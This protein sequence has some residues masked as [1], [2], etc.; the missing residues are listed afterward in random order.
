MN[1]T[2][3]QSPDADSDLSVLYPTMSQPI[4]SNEPMYSAGKDYGPALRD[5]MDE[6]CAHVG[7]GVDDREG[8]LQDVATTFR[9]L[10]ISPAD[11]A[12]LHDLIVGGLKKP[13]SPDQINAWNR[14][15]ERD[16]KYGFGEKEYTRRL[17]LVRDYLTRRLFLRDILT[18][19]GMG[20]HPKVVMALLK[21]AY[22]LPRK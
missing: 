2:N 8:Y 12:P 20:S 18:D 11:A 22:S 4:E 14:E 1:T 7:F 10:G 13:T 19:T 15:I 3:T 9:E 16:G 21:Q 6:V 17:D 5:S